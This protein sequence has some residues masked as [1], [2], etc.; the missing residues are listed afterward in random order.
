MPGPRMGDVKGLLLACASGSLIAPTR[1]GGT[2]RAARA[3]MESATQLD[4]RGLDLSLEWIPRDANSD[5][6]LLADG[7]STGFRAEH[8]VEAEITKLGWFVLLG[9]LDEGT[10]FF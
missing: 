7:D 6:D 9:I 2:G 3:A 1:L 4:A 8:R 10:S 5:A